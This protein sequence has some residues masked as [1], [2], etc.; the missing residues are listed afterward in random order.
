M[1]LIIHGVSADSLFVNKYNLV[2]NRPVKSEDEAEIVYV[3]K[4]G[5]RT[6]DRGVREWLIIQH[7]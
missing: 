1:N 2:D 6:G 3:L 7:C 4:W 5:L